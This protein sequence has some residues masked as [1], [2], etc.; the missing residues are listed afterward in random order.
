MTNEA[1]KHTGGE[2]RVSH[3]QFD[4]TYSVLAPKDPDVKS[5]HPVAAIV[6]R[7]GGGKKA[8]GNAYLIS[9]VRELYM[10]A[11]LEDSLPFRTVQEEGLTN[12]I[13]MSMGWKMDMP[14]EHFMRAYRKAAIE[15]A[16]GRV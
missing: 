2:W 4:D 11:L 16:E 5:T 10:L 7:V 1:L 6:K 9:A 12:H 8:R 15:K 3:Q 14:L 13:A